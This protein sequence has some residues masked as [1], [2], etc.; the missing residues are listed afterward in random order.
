MGKMQHWKPADSP[1]LSV[2]TC[3]S[4]AQGKSAATHLPPWAI[5]HAA[6]S[7]APRSIPPQ[8]AQN[9]SKTTIVERPTHRL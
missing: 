9:A 2:E 8:A 1:Q 5:E 3:P 6:L 4:G 7:V